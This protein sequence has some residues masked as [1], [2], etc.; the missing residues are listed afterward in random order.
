[1]MPLIFFLYRKPNIFNLYKCN[2]KKNLSHY[3]LTL[4]YPQ[5]LKLL[6]EGIK[7]LYI[8]KPKF[9]LSDIIKFLDENPKIRS[10]NS[11]I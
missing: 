7:A 1:M 11:N 3:R 4:D 5:D 10:L 8:K 6:T 9:N 2:L